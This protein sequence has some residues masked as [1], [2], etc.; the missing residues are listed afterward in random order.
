VLLVGDGKLGQLIG[1]TLALTGCQLLVVGR[2]AQKLALL[3]RRGIATGTAEDVEVGAFDVAV[4]CTGN[5]QGFALAR[6]AL[7]PRGTLI[8]KSTYAGKLAVDA[9]ALVVDEIA[10]VGSRC[11]PF[12]PAL[13]VLA[14]GRVEVEPLIQ[15][16]YGLEE[17]LM[18]FA[19]ARAR[20]CLK[21]LLDIG[22]G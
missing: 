22:E 17:G 4:E 5:P 1:Q 8:L 6:G 19:K 21:V 16:R 12:A 20:G 18:A 9:S 15:A 14:A 2:H 7:R 3:T 13:R 10:V 11:G